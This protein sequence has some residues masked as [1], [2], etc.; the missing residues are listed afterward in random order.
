MAPFLYPPV[1]EDIRYSTQMRLTCSRSS[2]SLSFAIPLPIASAS[3]FP[4]PFVGFENV[5]RSPLTETDMS[6]D[7]SLPSDA[8]G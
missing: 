8:F 4:T 6:K 2:L 1:A 7:T 5:T 3:L